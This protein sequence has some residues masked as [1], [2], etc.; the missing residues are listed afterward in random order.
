MGTPRLILTRSWLRR[1]GGIDGETGDNSARRARGVV[2]P[3]A[4]S[5]NMVFRTGLGLR[6]CEIQTE[7]S[8]STSSIGTES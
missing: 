2:H 5:D 7:V 3:Q 8:A 6:K 4:S 1:N